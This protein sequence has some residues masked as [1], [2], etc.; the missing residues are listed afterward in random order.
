MKLQE[1]KTRIAGFLLLGDCRI[2]L[3]FSFYSIHWT[4]GEGG[5]I[6]IP[7]ESE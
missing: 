5:D 3:M 2:R 7:W 4:Q 6:D 1:I